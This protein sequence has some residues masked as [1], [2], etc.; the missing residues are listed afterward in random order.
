MVNMDFECSHPVV[1]I[2]Y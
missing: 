1:F 2:N